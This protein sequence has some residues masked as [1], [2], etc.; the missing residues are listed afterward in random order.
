[1]VT[2]KFDIEE[3]FENYK[4]VKNKLK[5]YFYQDLKFYVLPFMPEKF[6]GRVV[7]LPKTC[8][9]EKIYKKQ[10]LRIDKLEKDWN[11]VKNQFLKKLKK[12]FPE[13]DSV[14]ITISPQLYGTIGSYSLSKANIK[15]KPRYDRSIL[16]LQGLIINALTHY[17]LFDYKNKMFTYSQTWLEKQN[18][19]DEITSQI[20]PPKKPKSM[21]SILDT[22]FAGKLAEESSKYL[23]RLKSNSKTEIQKPNDLTKNENVV[24][25]LLLR[26]KNK[27]V[28]FEEISNWL[29][30]DKSE[31]KYSEY[32]ITKLIERLKKKLP[33]SL[34]QS[35]RGIGYILHV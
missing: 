12:I 23:E 27:L 32:A 25:N 4:T 18:R 21:T 22:E 16:S 3:Q 30:E 14:N 1:M 6:R 26:N 24:F 31:E 9:P 28:S 10:K 7:F 15:V 5:T 35:Q 8:E 20:L 13:I 11:M 33:K 19:A 17:F 34:I 2:F 29:W